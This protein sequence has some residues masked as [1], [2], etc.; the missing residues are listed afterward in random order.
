VEKIT[1]PTTTLDDFVGNERIHAADLLKVDVEAS[2][3][4]VFSGSRTCLE[5]RL[6]KHIPIE[7]KGIRLSEL[8]N[9]FNGF[10]PFFAANG[11]VPARLNL[12]VLRLLQ[13]NKIRS[14]NTITN[15]LFTKG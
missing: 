5:R 15:F 7:F 6:F 3:Y 2:E 14:E 1:V 8:G 12:R 9:D 11:Y 4:E 10:W 13:Q